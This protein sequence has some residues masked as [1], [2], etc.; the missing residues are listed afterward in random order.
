MN[1]LAHY[2]PSPIPDYAGNPL[3][4]ALPSVLTEMDAARAIAHFPALASDERLFGKELRLHCVD[5]LKDLVQPLPIHL[6]L[7]S[8]VSSILRSGYVSR[9]PVNAGTWRH[10]HTLSTN[11]RDLA[12]FHSSASTFSLVGLSGIGKTT[13]LNAV[14]SLY[15][16]KI[17]HCRYEGREFL[18]T[19]IVWLKIECPFDG[20]LSGLCHAFFKALDKALDE[21]GRHS[22][23]FRSKVGIMEMIHSMEQL[24]STYFIGALVI[25]ELQHLNAAKTGGK[26]NMLNFFVNLINSIGIPVVFAGTN[27]MINLFA[28]VL[29]NAR[30]ACGQGMYDFRQPSEADAAW[31]M[32]VD[33]I[34]RYQWIQKPAPLTPE[35]RKLLYDLTQGVTDF[36]AKLMILG[37]RYAMQANIETLN[38]HV[39]R[40][41]ADTKLKL[42]KPAIAALRSGDTAAMK[43][44]ED[45]LPPDEQLEALMR[46]ELSVS[47]SQLAALHIS[48][49]D[50]VTSEVPQTPAEKPVSDAANQVSRK[51]ASHADPRGA[52][53]EHGWL[54]KDVLEFS[55][56][57][58]AVA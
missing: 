28:D 45:L 1:N 38:E 46:N 33:V 44:F 30:R 23:R 3:I 12:L 14:L 8:A 20:S 34:W 6:E 10:L 53:A 16:Q 25:D 26:E 55:D 47:I 54:A 57:Y 35:L 31:N 18:H 24:A 36:L 5:R 2:T 4:E 9:N 21:P 49:A 19:Q 11:R 40:H 27:S 41:I 56:T 48:K 29:R 22:A 13:A 37:Q 51:I 32:L 7:E 52:L 42:L 17:V 39:F 58:H 15:P 50:K 43:K